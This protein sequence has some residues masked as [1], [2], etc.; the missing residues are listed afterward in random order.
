M[1]KPPTGMAT[2]SGMEEIVY[3]TVEPHVVQNRK[4]TTPSAWRL[5]SLYSPS[6]LSIW[7]A[8][9]L[10]CTPNTDPVL[11]WHA[12]QWHMDIRIG[13]PR[14]VTLNRPQQQE[15]IRILTSNSAIMIVFK[16]FPVSSEWY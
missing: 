6:M 2:M 11:F 4:V 7:S 1:S 14:H 13:S 9:N 10:A 15:A 3:A 16:D 8:A 5:Y 12:K